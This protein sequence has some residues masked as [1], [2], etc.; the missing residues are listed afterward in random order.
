[1]IFLFNYSCLV[2]FFITGY[3]KY[4]LLNFSNQ[5]IVK[6]KTFEKRN[7]MASFRQLYFSFDMGSQY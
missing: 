2:V 4:K 5:E 1:M 6:T 7:I 3:N